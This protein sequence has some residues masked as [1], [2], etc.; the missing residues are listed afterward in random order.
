MITREP[1][2]TFERNFARWAAELR[3][4]RSGEEF[5]AFIS[6]RFVRER[7]NLSVRFDDAIGRLTLQTLQ[8][9]RFRYIL[10]KLT[11]KIDL[12]AYGETEGTRWL[13]T[14]V[15]GGYEIEHIFPQNPC[16]AALDEFGSFE[17]PDIAE[18]LGNLVLV[19]K[20]INASLGNR[21]YGEKQPVYRES[22]LLLT[23]ALA[24]KPKVGENTKIDRAVA[25]IESYETWNE[26]A[27]SARQVGLVS[28]SRTVWGLP[29]E[30]T[31]LP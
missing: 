10:A 22:K 11:Q 17:N 12:V 5:E 19:E 6:K 7:A 21:P 26:A 15:Q 4:V 16:Q 20:S 13:G 1:T 28:L 30:E 3:A 27:V 18:R 23:R 2:R 8:Q 31:E 9:Y 29:K 14:Y 24:E 25:S